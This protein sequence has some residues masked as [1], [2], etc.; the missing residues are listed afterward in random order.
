M[1]NKVNYEDKCGSCV[2]R[3][4]LVRKEGDLSDKCKCKYSVRP[5]Y[6]DYDKCIMYDKIKD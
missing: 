1:S 3:K 2:Y 4:P 6:A 5:V